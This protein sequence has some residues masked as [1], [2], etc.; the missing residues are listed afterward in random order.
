MHSKS[1]RK[2]SSSSRALAHPGGSGLEAWGLGFKVGDLGF[3]I[4]DLR[5]SA[6]N[7]DLGVGV[8]KSLQVTAYYAPAMHGDT[9]D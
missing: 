4:L 7:L 9:S 5:V 8:P 3:R 2:S 6:G 1:A